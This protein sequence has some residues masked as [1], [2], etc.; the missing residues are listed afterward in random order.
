MKSEAIQEH[1][2]VVGSVGEPLA[3]NVWQWV[4]D[5]VGRGQVHVV[6]TFFQTETGS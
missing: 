6:D 5:V 1:L 2:R 4:H 3:A